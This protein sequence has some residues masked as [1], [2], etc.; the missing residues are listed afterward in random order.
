MSLFFFSMK[1]WCHNL[2]LE[3]G[4]PRTVS[5]I[6]GGGHI[7]PSTY[8]GAMYGCYHRLGTL[9]KKIRFI[10][11]MAKFFLFGRCLSPTNYIPYEKMECIAFFINEY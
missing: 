9:P 8:T 7:H 10:H 1:I 4:I 11:S 3:P 2:D 6:T 5:Y